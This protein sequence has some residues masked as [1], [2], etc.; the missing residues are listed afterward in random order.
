[1][2]LLPPILIISSIKTAYGVILTSQNL[3]SFHQG[4]LLNPKSASLSSVAHSKVKVGKPAG[5][6]DF[7]LQL[8]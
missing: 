7:P 4:F 2:K 6:V 3:G 1:M 8:S 5:G